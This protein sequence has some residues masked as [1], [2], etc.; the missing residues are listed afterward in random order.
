ML[1]MLL[2]NESKYFENCIITIYIVKNKLLCLYVS[3][4]FK[5]FLEGGEYL[6]A[7]LDFSPRVIYL[8]SLLFYKFI[9]G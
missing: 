7:N 8:A 3:D 5:I 6:L 2:L 4:V 1:N 9:E